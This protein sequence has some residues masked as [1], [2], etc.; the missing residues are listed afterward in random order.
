LGV[1]GSVHTT[2]RTTRQ[3]CNAARPPGATNR[4]QPHPPTHPPTHP[5][6]RR[7]SRGGSGCAGWRPARRG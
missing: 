4:R 7:S 6:V 1:C 2:R 5:P 3:Q